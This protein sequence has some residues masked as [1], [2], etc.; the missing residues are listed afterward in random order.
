MIYYGKVYRAR[1][2]GKKI[3]IGEGKKG[4]LQDFLSF[5]IDCTKTSFFFSYEWQGHTYPGKPLKVVGRKP[6]TKPPVAWIPNPASG[7]YH[8]LV[9]FQHGYNLLH[10]DPQLPGI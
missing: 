3:Y 5:C 10:P 7:A 6:T 1:T 4:H 8:E 9:Y 2:S